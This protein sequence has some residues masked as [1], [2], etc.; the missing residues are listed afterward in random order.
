MDTAMPSHATPTTPP[1]VIEP[2]VLQA[3]LGRADAPL[4]LDVR[5][6]D[7]F[8]T[9]SRIVAGAVRCA[10]E[11]VAAFARQHA[12]RDVVVVYCVYGH[13][14]SADAAAQL[15]AAGWNAR[16]LAG[17]IEGGEDGVDTVD[18]IA[19]WR[20][21]AVPTTAKH[22]SPELT[23]N[24]ADNFTGNSDSLLDSTALRDEVNKR[25]L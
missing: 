4:I 18:N 24:I 17:G 16:A 1:F 3:M 2:I 8:D 14:V 15:R 11:D 9:S 6:A 13:N 22:A 21:Q 5:R 19:R 12:A 23:V 25:V 7:K 10:P 20:S